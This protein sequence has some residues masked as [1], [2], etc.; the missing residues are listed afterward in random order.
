M[1]ALKGEMVCWFLP[2]QKIMSISH[3]FRKSLYILSLLILCYVAL[4]F[5]TLSFVKSVFGKYCF[6]EV[7]EDVIFIFLHCKEQ[8][9]GLFFERTSSPKY[10]A[11][12]LLIC[13]HFHSFH[14][15]FKFGLYFDI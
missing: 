4:T 15:I 6:R 12:V 1:L 3:T 11:I 13:L 10:T 14:I 5:T 8:E 7:W 2:L 9:R